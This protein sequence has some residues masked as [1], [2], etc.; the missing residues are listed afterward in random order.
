MHDRLTRPRP[1]PGVVLGLCA[2]LVLNA[3]EQKSEPHP[4]EPAPN[5]NTAPENQTD[6]NV[7]SYAVRGQVV[8]LPNPANPVTE[9]QIRHEHIPDF[10]GWDGKLHI[11]AD[12]VP[13]MKSMTMPFTADPPS[14]IDTLR[15]GDKIRFTMKMDLRAKR[16]WISDLAKLDDDTELDFADKLP[17]AGEG[18]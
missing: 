14:L 17:P 1:A 12:G 18:P 9:L 8:L 10:V 13:G 15:V 4:N 16:Y 11:N 7:R 6:A 3:C 2:L 5:M